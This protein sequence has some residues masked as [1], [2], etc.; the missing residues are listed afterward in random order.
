MFRNTFLGSLKALVTGLI[1]AAA[2]QIENLFEPLSPHSI[3]AFAGAG[4]GPAVAQG[5]TKPAKTQHRLN[6][7]A[8][9]SMAQPGVHGHDF[10][11]SGCQRE[12]RH[13]VQAGITEEPIVN[14]YDDAITSGAGSGSHR[15][16]I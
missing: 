14:H 5:S 11:S 1:S 16:V 2:A 9:A 6:K 3:L 15:T 4:T 13:F 8:T 7:L 12:S 10:D